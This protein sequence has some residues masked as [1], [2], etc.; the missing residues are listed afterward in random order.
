LWQTDELRV[1]SWG[2]MIRE[3]QQHRLIGT[4]VGSKTAPRATV[5][6]QCS[7]MLPKTDVALPLVTGQGVAL[8]KHG[9]KWK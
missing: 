6:A 7:H 1:S 5:G 8:G 4:R 2:R 3:T 9:L